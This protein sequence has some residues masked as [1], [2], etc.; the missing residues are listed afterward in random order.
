M[1]GTQRHPKILDVD[2]ALTVA[3][4]LHESVWAVRPGKPDAVF[5]VYPGGRIENHGPLKKPAHRP[6]C[7]ISDWACDCDIEEQ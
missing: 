4:L 5:L 2:D 1:I 7:S 6:W 3:K